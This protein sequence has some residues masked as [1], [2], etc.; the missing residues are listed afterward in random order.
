MDYCY[1]NISNPARVAIYEQAIKNTKAPIWIG[2]ASPQ[3]APEW[4]GLWGKMKQ[5]IS[6]FWREVERL[7]A[8]KAKA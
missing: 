5:N 6:Y 4:K 1:T 2:E 3:G 7:D 8:E